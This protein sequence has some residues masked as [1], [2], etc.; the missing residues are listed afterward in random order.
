M[1]VRH[2]AKLSTPVLRAYLRERLPDYMLPAAF[3]VLPEL[4]L[5]ANGK[6]ERRALPA[7][8]QARSHL[9]HPFVPPRDS[10]ECRLAQVWEEVLGIQ[11]VGATDSF[12]DLGGHSILAVRLMFEISEVAGREL[13]L[14]TLFQA[15]TIERLAH[16]I[17]SQEDAPW[18]PLVAIQPNGSLPPLFCVQAHGGGAL[19]YYELAR[20]LGPDQPFYGL[21]APGLGGEQEAFTDIGEMARLYITAMRQVQPEGPYRLGGHSFGGLMVYEMAQQLRAQGQEIALL[22]IF[23]TPAP[24]PGNLPHDPS[25]MADVSDLATS[26]VD[27]ARLVSRI[28]LRDV[29]LTL[30]ELRPLDSEAQLQ[31]IFNKLKAFGFFPAGTEIKSMRGLLDVHQINAQ[32]TWRY[33]TQAQPLA[34]PLTLFIAENPTTEDHHSKP[35][36]LATDPTLGWST[37]VGDRVECYLVPGDHISLMTRPHVETLAARL[38]SCLAAQHPEIVA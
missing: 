17:R 26:L 9:G 15:P 38:K 22:A 14:A 10:L 13:P 30:D 27:I 4:P 31:L 20:Q 5:N 34:Q 19:S 11:P 21:Q 2:S 36:D 32:I 8:D 18:S 7:P 16:V 3:V 25:E 29:P 28:S 6:V 1:P 12:F 23:D 33:F 24:V 37:L 35:H